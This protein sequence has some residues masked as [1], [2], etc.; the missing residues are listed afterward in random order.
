MGG[1]LR[2]SLGALLLLAALGVLVG[3]VESLRAHDY[4]GAIVL[5]IAGL[6]LVGAGTELLRP[7]IG[8]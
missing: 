4:L 8:E 7:S 5:S 2:E 6:A 1:R 3:V